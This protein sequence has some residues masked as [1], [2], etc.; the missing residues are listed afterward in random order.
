MYRECCIG[1]Q[2]LWCGMKWECNRKGFRS[3][4]VA[5]FLG[6]GSSHPYESVLCETRSDLKA[7]AVWF[8]SWL[9]PKGFSN[10]GIPLVRHYYSKQSFEEEYGTC[11]SAFQNLIWYC[12][13]SIWNVKWWV[14][15][16]DCIIANLPRSSYSSS[17]CS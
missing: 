5:T 10:S 8:L 13:D 2:G 9:V 15:N 1:L 3:H 7:F 17:K 14:W 11:T 4:V 16:C 12:T 6:C